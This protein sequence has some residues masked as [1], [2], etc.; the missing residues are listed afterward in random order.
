MGDSEIF[1]F[2]QV[3]TE[4]KTMIATVTDMQHPC[5]Q[6]LSTLPSTPERTPTTTNLAPLHLHQLFQMVLRILT[7]ELQQLICTENAQ[8][9]ILEPQLLHQKLLE[10]LLLPLKQ[11]ANLHGVICNI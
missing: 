1:M 10:C 4:A 8:E 7:R 11:I 5:G 9:L 6:F 3:E 2:G